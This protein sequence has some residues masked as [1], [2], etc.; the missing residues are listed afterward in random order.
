MLEWDR[1]GLNKKCTGT[2]YTKLVFLHP[3]EFVGHVAHFVA[4][5]ARNANELFFK[6]QWDW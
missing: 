2:H 3:V 5:G 6:L 1:Y 4:S